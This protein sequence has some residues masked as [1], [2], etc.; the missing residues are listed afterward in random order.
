MREVELKF[1]L[2]GLR[3]RLEEKEGR[4]YTWEEI[5]RGAGVHP[6]TAY[7]MGK[8]ASKR[9]ALKTIAAF[10][11]YFRHQGLD[12]THADFFTFSSL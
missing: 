4:Q 12:V 6:H 9:V 10:L 8:G 7:N 3:R 1:N 5:A 2:I 11:T